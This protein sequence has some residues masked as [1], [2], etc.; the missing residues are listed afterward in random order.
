MEININSTSLIFKTKN[1]GEQM[2]RQERRNIERKIDKDRQFLNKLSKQD[3]E[4]MHNMVKEITESNTKRYFDMIDRNISALLVEEGYTFKEISE[5]MD[6]MSDSILEDEQKIKLLEKENTNMAKLQE[7]TRMYME[8]IIREGATKK[9]VVDKTLFKFPNLSK[10]AVLNAYGRLQEEKEI[11]KAAE[12]I[13]NSKEPKKTKEKK[14]VA[15]QEVIVPKTETAEKKESKLKIIETVTKM[16]GEFF[17]YTASK[18]KVEFDNVKIESLQDL[19]NYKKQL[20][21]ENGELME[22][23]IKNL[24]AVANSKMQEIR[25][26]LEIAELGA[27]NV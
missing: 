14:K 3:I 6:K 17:L 12:Y 4:R 5:L 10:T 9:E 27:K 19:D 16:Q 20:E 1:E 26:V 18:G 8:G 13:V 23:Y 11:E 25:E 15:E 7:E 24:N 22:E 21:K 2:N